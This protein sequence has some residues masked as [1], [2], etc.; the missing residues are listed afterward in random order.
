MNAATMPNP[1][2]NPGQEFDFAMM[3]PNPTSS[4]TK[5]GP[6]YRLSVEVSR[7]T[8]DMFMDANTKGMIVGSRAFVVNQDEQPKAEKP[9]AEPK[10]FGKA[11][12]YRHQGWLLNPAVLRAIGTDTAFLE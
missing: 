2:D 1:L 12:S 5:D 9:K 3:N 10:P 7:E 8:W 6:V 11:A 4:K